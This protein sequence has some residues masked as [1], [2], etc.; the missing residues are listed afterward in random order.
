[1]LSIKAIQELRE[2]NQRQQQ[3]LLN[4]EERLRKLETAPGK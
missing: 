4:M 2:I 1:V 3:L